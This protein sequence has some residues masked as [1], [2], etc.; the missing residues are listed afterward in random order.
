M[1][2]EQVRSEF[3]ILLPGGEGARAA[4]PI[5]RHLE[6]CP[7]CRSEFESLRRTW[8]LLGQL[9]EAIP[10]HA[11]ERR[12]MR[13]VKLAAFKESV[14]TVEAWASAGRVAL[15]G[16][17]LSIGLSLLVPYES[18]VAVCRELMQATEPA[19]VPY[20]VAGM[21]YGV[22][23]AVGAWLTRRQ[24]RGGAMIGA[25]ESSLLFLVLLVPYVIVRCRDFTPALVLTFVSGLAVGAVAPTMASL[26]LAQ[27][28]RAGPL[29][30]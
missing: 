9:P 4:E 1:E 12:L 27:R 10:G 23:L 22:P 28:R 29:R 24:L 6:E 16:I 7:G 11:I 26:W 8:A 19:E 30:S 3:A 20:L 14:L 15:I 21:A 18:L 5:V 25:V 17:A 13:R 2:C